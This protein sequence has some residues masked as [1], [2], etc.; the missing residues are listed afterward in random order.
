[1]PEEGEPA[2]S[3]AAMPTQTLTAPCARLAGRLLATLCV[4]LA[5]CQ[6]AEDA[7]APSPLPSPAV[8]SA[9]AARPDRAELDRLFDWAEAR[10]PALFPG[11]SAT[12]SGSGFAYRHYP[13]SGNYAGVADDDGVSVY[14]LGPLSGGA[15]QRVGTVDAFR[16]LFQPAGCEPAPPSQAWVADVGAVPLQGLPAADF[17]PGHRFTL[18]GWIYLT[19]RAPQAW[20]AGKANPINGGAG[21]LSIVYGLSFD[22]RGERLRF[23]HGPAAE[24]RS[25]EALPLRRW[26]HVAAV[27][28]DGQ[29][30][31]LINGT[32][33]ATRT[34]AE[35]VPAAPTLPLGL[36][37]PYD[38]AGRAAANDTPLYARHWRYWR[39]A[40]SAA[41][42]AAAMPDALPDVRD[43]L[44]AAWPLDDRR[45]DR[46]RDLLGARPLARAE[47][48]IGMLRRAVLEDGPHFEAAPL[49][50]PGGTMTDPSDLALIDFD[51]NGWPDLFVAQVAFPPTYPETRR[52][53]LAL[54]N[55]NGAFVDATAA[56][57]GELNLVNPR[58]LHV[59]DF[60]RDGRPDLFLAETGT[61][62]LP[63][64]GSQSRLLMGT[65]DGR[66]VDESARR[67]PQRNEYTHGLAVADVDG[68]GDLDVFMGNY[69]PYLLRLLRNDGVGV[70]RDAAAGAL[71]AALGGGLRTVNAA[72]LCDLT[73]DG[74]PDLAISADYYGPNGPGTNRPNELFRND[75][76]GNFVADD[77]LALPPKLHGIEG[78]TTDIACADLDGDGHLDLVLATDRGATVPGLQL[79]L[80]DGSGRLRDASSQLELRWA[81][82]DAW[83]NQIRVVDI[84]GDGRPDLL[85]RTNSRSFARYNHARTL[86][87]NLGGGRFVDASEALTANLGGGVAVGDVDRDGR[88]DL[89]ALN[90]RDRLTVWRQLKPLSATL[91]VD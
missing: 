22:E 76:R 65:A 52:R 33:V 77:R 2:P 75:G 80:N 86:L 42:I 73:G 47:S 8:P 72:S 11:A 5:A 87:L 30:R 69:Q 44:V 37:A 23:F 24:L 57:L 19:E 90:G 15:V 68:D 59:A 18:E 45:G 26:T 7:E 28:G 35:A 25:P 20:V 13:A 66:L 27:L 67:L 62:T 31:L 48:Q 17:E 54:R 74:W 41:Q 39:S 84:N 61:D 83:V 58:R 82:G 63:V 21:G 38:A 16:C 53:Q 60:D 79:L 78:V 71:P 64:P 43:G 6:G 9:T 81:A 12:L 55:V 1:M 49:Q 46:A 4:A 3:S 50:L 14:V 56:V 70:L 34:A 29:A 51:G 85:L 89:V 10:Y 32:V 40:R 91:F 36:G 88:P